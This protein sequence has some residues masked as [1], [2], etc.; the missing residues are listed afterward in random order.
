MLTSEMAVP[1]LAAITTGIVGPIITYLVK[2][3]LEQKRF[4]SASKDRVN[5]LLKP[6]WTGIFEQPTPDAPNTFMP[7]K[8]NLS[9]TNKGKII[10]GEIRLSAKIGEKVIE[11]IFSIRN[12]VFDGRM[13]KLEYS[14]K[15]PGVFQNGSLMLELNEYADELNGCIVGYSP[16]VKEIIS[17]DIRFIH[18][19]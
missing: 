10:E 4:P 7:V 19:N 17:G 18:L 11:P 6:V 3:R 16:L 8:M 2:Y 1:I 5:K 9:L 15:D 13:F 14:N 12:G